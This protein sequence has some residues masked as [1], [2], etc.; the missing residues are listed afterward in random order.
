MPA[1]FTRSANTRFRLAL[2]ALALMLASIPVLL[3]LYM[4][5]P[6][7]H[8]QFVPVDQP[9]EFDHRH[10]VRD[11][12]I[13]CLYCH[14]SAER[15]ESAGV[16][17]TEVCMGCHNQIWN[18]SVLIEPIRRSYFGD[19][20]IAWNRVYALPEHVFF[21]HAVHVDNGVGCVTCHG[22]VDL[23]ARVYKV[24]PLTMQWCLDC[25]RNPEPHLRPPEMITAMDW[26]PPA[27]EADGRRLAR[28]YGVRRL[29]HCTT[30][31]R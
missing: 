9:I 30:C 14:S 7:A 5:S 31:H 22:R 20:P 1:L 12:G 3:V 26:T 18:D 10:H 4:R 6:D 11:D 29:T 16:P 27:G 13:D 19:R 23:M 25:H 15:S 24:P 17:P 8:A 2:T 21:N 28:E